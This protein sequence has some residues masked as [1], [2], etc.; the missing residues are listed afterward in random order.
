MA[1]FALLVAATDYADPMFAELRSPAQDVQ[2]LAAVLAMPEIGGYTVEVLVNR[3]E[4][5]IRRAVEDVLSD[6]RPDDMVLL[7]FSCHGLQDQFG[8]LHFA[9]T[10]T[11]HERL[12]G[13]AVAS[14]FVSEQ[15]EKSA[16][17]SRLLLLDCCHSG[18]F[19]RG[20][21]KGNGRPLAEMIP[22]S[23]G[24]VCI[25]ACDEYEYAFEGDHRYLNAPRMS[26][27]TDAVI[28]GIRTGDADRDGDGW[29]GAHELYL[30]ASTQVQSDNSGRQ[31]PRFF[32]ASLQRDLLVARAPTGDVPVPVA[33]AP[34]P[35][36][37]SISRTPR[38]HSARFPPFTFARERRATPT[39]L[40]EQ[41]SL[42][43]SEAADLF[44]ADHDREALLHWIVNDVEDRLLPRELLR[45]RPGDRAAADAAVATFVSTFAP[46]LRPRFCG[47]SSDEAGLTA[48]ALATLRGDAE[49]G[50]LLD[51]LLRHNVLRAFADHDCS[52]RGHA[53]GA[54]RPCAVL[55]TA[56]VTWY[57]GWTSAQAALATVPATAAVGDGRLAAQL[58]LLAFDRRQ[59]DRGPEHARIDEHAPQWWRRL[60]ALAHAEREQGNDGPWALALLAGDAARAEA[61]AAHR[62]DIDSRKAAAQTIRRAKEEQAKQSFARAAAARREAAERAR[63]EQEAQVAATRAAAEAT[64]Q[65]RRRAHLDQA[66]RRRRRACGILAGGAAVGLLALVVGHWTA[67]AAIAERSTLPGVRDVDLSYG[68]SDALVG[69][70]VL[71]PPLTV[72]AWLYA[73]YRHGWRIRQ[74]GGRRALSGA[75]VL[76]LVVSSML[77]TGLARWAAHEKTLIAAAVQ[78]AWNAGVLV[79]PTGRP[80]PYD[81]RATGVAPA[82]LGIGV[83]LSDKSGDG[84]RTV[85]LY[86]NSRL[87]GTHQLPDRSYFAAAT[88]WQGQRTADGA[89]TTIVGLFAAKDG[90]RFV[91]LSSAAPQRALWISRS[92][93]T[94]WNPR[95]PFFLRLGDLLVFEGASA[96][97]AVRINDGSVAWQ[98]GCADGQ[99]Y[100]GMQYRSPVDMF[101]AYR[102][103]H[104]DAAGNRTTR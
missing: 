100:A 89:A 23:G 85:R 78:R 38:F 53:C 34:G 44:L 1:R 103:V 104:L 30:Y 26:L 20:F 49:T 51:G 16:A 62:Q 70:A 64:A 55:G 83:A 68:V 72:G 96:L 24:Y 8:R 97:T 15:L 4:W 40:A 7:Y 28:R 82:S 21:A 42:H 52:D 60:V 57:A 102:L 58:L 77:P 61:A 74:R 33:P 39:A 66:R 88:S 91:A 29:I 41:M 31:T 67:D 94:S 87:L 6:R 73:R 75:T 47:R 10:D 3:A 80:I 98:R 93:L 19:A 37:P 65:R 18:S 11:D 25:T 5:E 46:H 2:A 35:V 13:T 71:S 90:W 59:H 63:L 95:S 32:A 43:W 45:R 81:C 50:Q 101:C 92:P 17:G 99:T 79:D 84:C 27:F 22:R 86:S 69:V 12:A 76:L 9:T 54:G 36:D 48:M 56:A 14:A